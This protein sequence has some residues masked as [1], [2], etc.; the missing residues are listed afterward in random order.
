MTELRHA[1]FTSLDDFKAVLGDAQ[2]IF[3]HVFQNEP[4]VSLLR[5]FEAS[6]KNELILLLDVEQDRGFLK[7]TPVTVEITNAPRQFLSKPLIELRGL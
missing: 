4:E 1:A 3:F 2:L 7:G 5:L 6:S